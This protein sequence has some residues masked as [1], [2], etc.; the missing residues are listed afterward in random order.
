MLSRR[1][2]DIRRQSTPHL[3]AVGEVAIVPDV[4]RPKAE[5]PPAVPWP[6][7]GS[8]QGD[9]LRH[10]RDA[11]GWSLRQLA[12]ASGVSVRTIR[13]IESGTKGATRSDVMAALADALRV[14]RGWLTFGG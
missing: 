11:K 13:E 7:L 10:S 2:M 3:G 6:D 1:E 9:R 4:A 5:R 14:P 12:A 8:G